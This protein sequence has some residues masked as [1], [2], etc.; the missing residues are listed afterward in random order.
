[1]N[2]QI[3]NKQ[4]YIY[5]LKETIRKSSFGHSLFLESSLEEHV[6]TKQCDLYGACKPSCSSN[7]HFLG[8]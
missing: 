4:L 5:H 7:T 6:F 8:Q 1:M 2:K 3:N